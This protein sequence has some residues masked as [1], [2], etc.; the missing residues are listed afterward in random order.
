MKKTEGGICPKCGSD[1]VEITDYEMGLDYLF[2]EISCCDCGC[3][4]DDAYKIQYDGY[5]IYENNKTHVFD[6]LGNETQTIEY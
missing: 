3:V 4:F 5:N 2:Q 1:N 6:A